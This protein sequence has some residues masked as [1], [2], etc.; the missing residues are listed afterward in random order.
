MNGK[1]VVVDR[2]AFRVTQILRK[3]GLEYATATTGA[4]LIERITRERPWLVILED[5]LPDG[6]VWD[7]LRKIAALN[8]MARPKILL[9]TN[10]SLEGCYS[11]PAR[12]SPDIILNK[13]FDDLELLSFI[14]MLYRDALLADLGFGGS[15][16]AFA[17]IPEL[18][19]EV[20]VHLPHGTLR[21]VDVFLPLIA[22]IQSENATVE[23]RIGP[24]ASTAT[25]SGGE[26]ETV[27]QATADSI[28]DAL[29][30]IV[31]A[32]AEIHWKQDQHG[33]Q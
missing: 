15:G 3:E 21:G 26:M 7:V 13:P 4:E 22:K 29:A 14:R 31:V 23:L 27:L 16:A 10:T 9:L 19:R 18:A 32:Y 12:P 20:N 2:Q 24:D 5:A 8:S 28:E 11:G 25:L 6:D 17:R 30:E 33:K 1:V